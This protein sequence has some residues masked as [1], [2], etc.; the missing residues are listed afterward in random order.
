MS[1]EEL[2]KQGIE[3]FQLHYALETLQRLGSRPLKMAETMNKTAVR[4]P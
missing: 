3:D 1:A 4:K 2:K